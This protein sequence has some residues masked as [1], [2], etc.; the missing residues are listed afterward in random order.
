M[1]HDDLKEFW[2]YIFPVSFKGLFSFLNCIKSFHN[3]R[4]L[5][6]QHLVETRKDLP[7]WWKSFISNNL[8]TWKNTPTW[9]NTMTFLEFQATNQFLLLVSLCIQSKYVKIYRAAKTQYSGFFFF[10]QCSVWKVHP[11]IYVLKYL[12]FLIQI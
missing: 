12:Q 1:K 7:V 4:T 10:L 9:P 5:I 6:L 8:Q 2:H 3:P 11:Y